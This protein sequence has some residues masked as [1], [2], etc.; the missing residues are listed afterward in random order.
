MAEKFSSKEI[1]LAYLFKILGVTGSRYWFEKS[2]LAAITIRSS[3]DDQICHLNHCSALDK[4][5][6]LLYAIGFI[7][8]K[9]QVISNHRIFQFLKVIFFHT[10]QKE[11]D[12][13]SYSSLLMRS[14]NLMVV[15]TQR[16]S[17]KDWNEEQQ[18]PLLPAPRS[19][20]DWGSKGVDGAP[21][22][23]LRS[24]TTGFTPTPSSDFFAIS[25]VSVFRTVL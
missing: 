3:Q 20:S 11:A 9:S 12:N 15:V 10:I 16:N 21:N 19:G 6:I 18:A 2:S 1:F 4:L 7:W 13:F 17:S 23:D 22:P 14:S 8:S 24:T 5:Q 25:W